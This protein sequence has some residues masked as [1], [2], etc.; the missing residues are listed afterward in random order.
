M[1]FIIAQILVV[2]AFLAAIIIFFGKVKK[3]EKIVV[4]GLC[5]ITIAAAFISNGVLGV[6]PM[7]KDRI[8]LTA[9][10]E[11]GSDT[12]SDDV[13]V[14]GVI[15]DDVRYELNNAVDGKWFW[16]GDRYMWRHEGNPRQPEGVTRSIILEIPK[17]N[18]R[19]LIFYGTKY[20][21]M[22]EITYDGQS[23]THDLYSENN[24]DTIIS[25]PGNGL[26]TAY[27]IKFV[28]LT[29]FTLFIVVLLVYF[30]FAALKFDYSV[31]KAWFGRNWDKLY[32]AAIAVIY[33]F[34]LQSVS[35]EGSLWSDE[36]WHLGCYYT[37]GWPIEQTTVFTGLFSLWIKI[38]PYGQEYLRLLSQLFVAGA[39]YF[40]GLIGSNYKSKRLGVILSSIVAFS[41]S[42]IYQCSLGIRDY[43]TMLFT[44]TLMIYLFVK[45]QD[46]KDN[47]KVVGMILYGLS[48]VL[49]MD[50][51]MMN[52][53][54][55]G[56]LLIADFILILLKKT[57]KKGWFEFIFPAIYGVYWMS[58]IFTAALK[59]V[60]TSWW[61]PGELTIARIWDFIKWVF[62]YN[63]VMT[64]VAVTGFVCI[65]VRTISQLIK[66]QFDFNKDFTALV[67]TLIPFFQI[68]IVAVYSFNAGSKGSMFI[69][70]YFVSSFICMFFVLAVG[71]DI[72]IDLICGI[73]K[74]KGSASIVTVIAVC[75]M[76]LYS[77]M[78][79]SPWNP[80][81]RSYR[82]NNHDFKST[83]EYVMR[84]NDCYCS[85]TIFIVDHNLYQG[86]IGIK[87]YITH[88]GERD[89]INRCSLF[90]LP[91]NIQD[92][93]T[94]YISSCIY[95]GDRVNADLNKII[96]KQYKLVSDDSNAKI[97]KYVKKG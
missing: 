96:D 76:S 37:E 39:I 86:Q 65:I 20:S 16:E 30:V 94:I 32:Y 83:V 81:N 49:A 1:K 71:L 24:I 90:Q 31:I 48:I 78:Q 74:I 80:W 47:L 59:S 64:F 19:Q 34:V 44:V 21:G 89:D 58:H 72:I 36:M 28:R 68:L 27:L 87:Y 56:L 69:D 73:S 62:S 93:S 46:S 42:V 22:V 66:K 18:V 61:S 54:V 25:I 50:I 29:L 95:K 60:S 92:Y 45:K 5:I 53:A 4:T 84:Q 77:W 40:A 12:L 26:G 55:A 85:S 13:S 38:M 43:A 7:P 67:I 8:Q 15:V 17:G 35:A 51:H 41:G 11:K 33:I 75:T 2:L 3:K 91:E 14:K 57:S 52:V 82:T 70:R 9:T 88:N 10:G 97:K 6:I 63:D 23:E 79:I